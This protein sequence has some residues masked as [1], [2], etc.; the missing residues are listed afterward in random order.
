MTATTLVAFDPTDG[1]GVRLGP[2]RTFKA[3]A[4]IL[5]GSLVAFDAS[6]EDDYVSPAGTTLGA[7]VG[8]ALNSQATVGGEVT[9]A[10]DGSILYVMMAADDSAIDAGH[11]LM[12]GSVAGTAIEYDPAIGAHAATQDTQSTA[13]IGKAMRNSVAGAATVGSKVLMMIQTSPQQT[14]SS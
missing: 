1:E 7:F 8:V 11:W 14:A 3:T 2:T 6:G 4:A 10:M 9:V 5:R 12:V 13:P